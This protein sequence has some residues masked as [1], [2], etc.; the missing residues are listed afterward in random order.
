MNEM[1]VITWSA[2]EYWCSAEK[3]PMAKAKTMMTTSATDISN[4]VLG[5]RSQITSQAVWPRLMSELPKSPRS[6]PLPGAGRLGDAVAVEVDLGPV[7]TDEPVEIL[8]V[9]RLVQTQL[10]CQAF[11]VVRP[12]CATSAHGGQGV[13]HV[14]HQH[15]QG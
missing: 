8:G 15:K 3:M 7:V 2:I 1:A 12:G 9:N 6:T 13:T 14:L 4:K 10:P 5:M 11:A